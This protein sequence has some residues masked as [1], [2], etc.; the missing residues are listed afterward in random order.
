VTTGATIGQSRAQSEVDINV[1][2]TIGPGE[3]PL[4]LC[5]Q[6]LTLEKLSTAPNRSEGIARDDE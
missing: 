2:R 1:A 3:W 6:K 4:S 5:A